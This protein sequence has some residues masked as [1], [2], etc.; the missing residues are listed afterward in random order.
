M[1]HRF[2]PVSASAAPAFALPPLVVV[3]DQR[4]RSQHVRKAPQTVKLIAAAAAS[5]LYV[6]ALSEMGV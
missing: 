6:H 4:Q 5:L 1:T 3:S 2:K